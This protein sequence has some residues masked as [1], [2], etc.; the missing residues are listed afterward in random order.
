MLAC[1]AGT[2][3][4]AFA[5]NRLSQIS[6]L[7]SLVR[8]ARSGSGEA[9]ESLFVRYRKAVLQYASSLLHDAN[10]AEE[11]C[12]EFANKLNARQLGVTVGEMG[13]FRKFIKQT[14]YSLA[15]NRLRQHHRQG[16]RFLL[17]E[18]FPG[19]GRVFDEEWG[20]PC[21][22]DA[23]SLLEEGEL[24]KPYPQSPPYH[25]VLSLRAENG[26]A[27]YEDLAKLLSQILSEAIT[28]EQYRLWLHSARAQFAEHLLK[29]LEQELGDSCQ[30]DLVTELKDLGLYNYC[31]SAL[32]SRR[33]V[34]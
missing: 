1:S 22:D 4:R 14:T 30:G 25:S 21:L 13:S 5:V 7:G 11:V 26:D 19:D 32:E 17:D 8:K 29:V 28:A 23:W 10:E 3:D 9:L 2:E 16:G 15:M 27:S 24:E 12:T 6:T 34:P 20:R 31:K 33:L 18:G